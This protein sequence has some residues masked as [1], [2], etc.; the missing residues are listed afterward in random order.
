ME[1]FGNSAKILV[2][3][4][5]ITSTEHAGHSLS[6]KSFV[7]SQA[8]HYPL[9][10]SRDSTLTQHQGVGDWQDSTWKHRWKVYIT[11]KV[12]RVLSFTF[13]FVYKPTLTRNWLGRRGLLST[14]LELEASNLQLQSVAHFLDQICCLLSVA[15]L[16]VWIYT[17]APWWRVLELLLGE[18]PA[19]I[20]ICYALLQ[21]TLR[22][23]TMWL[24]QE[25]TSLRMPF[26]NK[27]SP[28]KKNGG[29]LGP[30]TPR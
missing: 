3:K 10:R 9:R 25:M 11:S 16:F 21:S 23:F 6:A 15:Q 30:F 26:E 4:Y 27:A 19:N 17:M 28:R 2:L 18:I 5:Y 22:H 1:R 13:L 7:G 14:L 24:G 29:R 12:A 20:R 8:L